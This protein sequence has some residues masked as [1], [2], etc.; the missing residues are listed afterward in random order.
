MSAALARKS[1]PSFD[2]DAALV[3]QSEMAAEEI[4]KER[5]L[6]FRVVRRQGCPC[7]VTRDHIVTRIN[8]AVEDGFVTEVLGKG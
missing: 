4:C 3:H 6:R 7:V 8:V 2:L 1:E 5:G